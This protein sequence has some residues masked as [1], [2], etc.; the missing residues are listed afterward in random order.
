MRI[1]PS[2]ELVIRVSPLMLGYS[3]FL[4]FHRLLHKPN[5]WIGS[6]F[7]YMSEFAAALYYLLLLVTKAWRSIWFRRLSQCFL[8]LL[9]GWWSISL[10]QAVS[11]VTTYTYNTS[12]QHFFYNFVFC[13]QFGVFQNLRP[14]YLSSKNLDLSLL[15]VK[16][17]VLSVFRSC[18]YSNRNSRLSFHSK[19]IRV[20]FPNAK[21]I[22]WN[23][24]Y[25]GFRFQCIPKSQLFDDH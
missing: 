22:I 5:I 2:A 7:E 9:L 23:T 21:V 6:V 18:C 24:K 12:C 17:L 13:S 20:F 19:H 10:A 25:I 11:E 14:Q 1:P 16:S 8:R 15:T 3:S 4:S